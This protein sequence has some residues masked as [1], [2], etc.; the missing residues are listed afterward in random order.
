MERQA[1][2]ASHSDWLILLAQGAV[3]HRHMLAWIAAADKT[4]DASAYFFDEDSISNQADVPHHLQPILR[5]TLDRNTLFE[6]NVYGETLAVRHHEFHAIFQTSIVETASYCRSLMLLEESAKA[7][8]GHIPL[9]LVSRH[10]PQETPAVDHHRAVMAH[11]KSQGLDLRE[12]HALPSGRLTVNPAPKDNQTRIAVIIGTRDGAADV[13]ALISSL[14]KTADRPDAL[15]IVVI[16]NG[17]ARPKDLDMLASIARDGARVLRMDEAFNWSRLNMNAAITTD[18]PYLLFLNDDMHMI[19]KRWDQYLRSF[20]ERADIGAI[21]A[22]LLYYD[23]T[24]QHGGMLFGWQGS[25]IHDGLYEAS[26]APGPCDRWQLT[27]RTGAVTGAFLAT[28][29]DLFFAMGGFDAADLPVAYSDIDYALK[30]RTKGLQIVWTPDITLYH[31]ES[32]TRRLDHTD[33]V[34]A[35]RNASERQV[36]MQRW[37]T[38]MVTDPSLNPTWHM[39]SLPF[40][41]LS[42]PSI[43]Q[44]L[45][46]IA[47]TSRSDPWRPEA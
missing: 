27:R 6:A 45:Q 10:A 38:A 26:T 12:A 34:R 1:A 47:L 2:A 42:A 29:R 7:T 40:R 3:P 16:D 22:R 37:G 17:S 24:I 14:R 13:A 28:R 11:A 32:K 19:S 31:H 20:L 9:P 41:L 44:I 39:A 18:A 43:A 35:A 15:E 4:C 25:V 23:D 36:M 46:Y 5:Q 33:T 30:L 8:V 21:G